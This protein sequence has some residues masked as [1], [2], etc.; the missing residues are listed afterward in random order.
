MYKNIP[1]LEAV[2]IILTGTIMTE[3]GSSKLKLPVG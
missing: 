1:Y 3:T 2:I